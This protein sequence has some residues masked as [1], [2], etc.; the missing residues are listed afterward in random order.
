M[1]GEFQLAP[2]PSVFAARSSAPVPSR[3]L[4]RKCA[5]GGSGNSGGECEECKKKEMMLQRHPAGHTGPDTVP[6]IVYDVLRSPGQPLDAETRAFFE[7]RFG[8]DFGKVLVHTG[9]HAEASA[10]SV[11]ALAYT[12]G[13]NVVFNLNQYAPTTDPG[14]RLLAHELAHSVQQR[15]STTVPDLL[16]FGPPA[17]EAERAAG[18]AETYCDIGRTDITKSLASTTSLRRRVP[19]AGGSSQPA[20][21]VNQADYIT[22]LNE[23]VAQMSGR[24]VESNTLAATIRPI[25][26]SMVAQA[27]WRDDKGADHG[28]ASVPFSFP[29][30]HS[31]R[32]NLQL[33]LD[34]QPTP[35]DSGLFE[36]KDP[37]HG[38]IFLRVQKNKNVDEIALTL[39]HESLHVMYWIINRAA[40]PQLASQ[41]SPQAKALL[42]SRVET[43]IRA[44]RNLLDQLAQ[45]VNPRRASGQ[46][47]I[48]P[49]A[50]DEMAPWL[51]QEIQV[52]AETEVF[53]Q[54]LQ[55]Q[56]ARQAGGPMVLIGTQA[57]VEVNSNTIAKY[58]FDFSKT[59]LP[60]DRTGLNDQDR[61]DLA[62]LTQVL[63]NFFKVSVERR[64]DPMLYSLGA[65]RERVDIPLPPLQPPSFLPK[66]GEATQGPP[67]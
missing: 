29:G 57:N 32:V 14:R 20:F 40:L 53:K 19:P 18:S 17:D 2:K 49:A 47:R 26:Q 10:R 31:L 5:C 58:V 16:N 6:P 39:F 13:R 50:L 41:H 63:Q 65:P 11:G 60:G 7:P 37:T 66:I 35:P 8:H 21:S 46:P 52:R 51:V 61:Q 1:S 62:D 9:A 45:S 64:F 42:A 3:I 54:Y 33:I 28:G 56:R 43:Q 27:T 48:T 15:F 34:D 59:F 36:G 44:V 24:L 38:K 55:V 22:K 30:S 12:V 23:A 4:Q 67:F 25:L